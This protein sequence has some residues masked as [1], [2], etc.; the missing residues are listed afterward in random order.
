QLCCRRKSD[1]RWIYSLVLL[2]EP[3]R[4]GIRDPCAYEKRKRARH[5][6]LGNVGKIRRK[7]EG[8]QGRNPE[9]PSGNVWQNHRGVR[10][11]GEKRDVYKFLRDR[12]KLSQN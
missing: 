12:Q 7:G 6:Q 8:P 4:T 9:A 5:K 11:I 10:G 1:Q 3:A 2:K